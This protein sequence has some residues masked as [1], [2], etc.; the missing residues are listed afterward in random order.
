M[1]GFKKVVVTS[2]DDR[3]ELTIKQTMTLRKAIVAT[4]G[5]QARKLVAA[6]IGPHVFQMKRFAVEWTRDGCPEGYVISRA[7]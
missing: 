6:V 1:S 5:D 4:T 2:Y 7:V 3:W